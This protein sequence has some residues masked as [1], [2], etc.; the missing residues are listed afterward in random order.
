[1]LAHLGDHLVTLDEL[2]D[3]QK[4]AALAHFGFNADPNA[5]TG[6]K[7][8]IVE[9][10]LERYDGHMATYLRYSHIVLAY[11]VFEDRLFAFGRILAATRKDVSDFSRRKGSG[12]L[13]AKFERYLNELSLPTPTNIAVEGLRLVRN[14]VVHCNGNIGD[15]NEREALKQFVA[16]QTEV[17]INQDGKLFLT[18]RGCLELQEGV[19]DY[20]REINSAAGLRMWIPPEVR[21]SFET[22]I[23]PFLQQPQDD[24]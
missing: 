20:L 4:H 7:R 23:L 11:L 8:Q 24:E 19:F 21:K 15:F 6:I 3:G 22:H 18:T 16:R 12:S 10:H 9:S 14:C 17:M 1:M 2:R 13:I 5:H